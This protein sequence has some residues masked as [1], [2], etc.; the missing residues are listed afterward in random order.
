MDSADLFVAT[1]CHCGIGESWTSLSTLFLDRRLLRELLKKLC[2]TGKDAEFYSEEYFY[3]YR[4]ESGLVHSTA[5][6]AEDY[7]EKRD[8]GLQ[9]HGTTERC[10]SNCAREQARECD[11]QCGLESQFCHGNQ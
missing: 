3:S 8:D 4:T 10:L 5:L 6:W 11:R 7:V 2:T 1:F 9:L